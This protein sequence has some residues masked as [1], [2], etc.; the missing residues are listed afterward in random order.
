MQTRNSLHLVYNPE[1]G[2]PLSHFEVSDCC[3]DIV[4]DGDLEQ[5]F[6]DESGWPNRV[7]QFYNA[8]VRVATGETREFKELDE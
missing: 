1:P 5:T 2:E 7:L 4:I 6:V 8:S 3:L